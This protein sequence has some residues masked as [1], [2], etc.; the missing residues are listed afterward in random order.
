VVDRPVP[1]V[2]LIDHAKVTLKSGAKV[3]H[4]DARGSSEVVVEDGAQISHLTAKGQAV[5]R[6]LGGRISNLS[7]LDQAQAH[8]HRLRLEGGGLYSST[9]S[10][11]GII[12][13]PSAR[14]HFYA[15]IISVDFGIVRGLWSNGERFALPLIETPD[16]DKGIYRRPASMPSQLVMHELPGPSFDCTRAATPAERA[17][18]ADEGL[19]KLDK[20]LAKLYAQTLVAAADA[21]ALRRAQTRWLRERDKCSSRACFEAAYRA[22]IEAITSSAEMTNQKAQAICKTVM[23]AVNDGSIAGRFLRFEPATAEDDKRWKESHPDQFL[24]LHQVL[25]IKHQG[26]TRAIGM[27]IGGGTCGNCD[28][29]DLDAKEIELYPPDDEK[30]RLRWAS[31][32]ACDHLLMVN[33]EPV[34][35]TGSFGGGRSRASLVAWIA[36]DGAKRALCYLGPSGAVNTRFVRSDNRAL[37]HAVTEGRV[38]AVPWLDS[39]TVEKGSDR[40][41]DRRS[42]GYKAAQFDVDM[43]GSKDMIVLYGYASGAGCGSYSEWLEHGVKKSRPAKPKTKAAEPEQLGIGYPVASDVSAG[44]EA[45]GDTYVVQDTPLGQVLKD[46]ISGPIEGAGEKHERFALKMFS[47]G[48]RPYILGRGDESSASVFSVWGGK[49]RTWC[50]FDLLRQHQI[51]LYYPIETWPAGASR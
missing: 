51:E 17:I 43:D 18:C 46:R 10:G 12:Y 24:N 48:G 4:L 42:D 31:W 5:V 44:E 13:E 49:P 36:P 41:H 21:P 20:Q 22:R 25:R 6:I 45:P 28:I 35:V 19:A 40:V 34:I 27:L 37:C 11:S 32:G 7:I 16:A 1:Y 15:D 14:I 26:R 29:V 9:F 8:L 38:D 33:G 3:A 30:E 39:F 50:D 2:D 23:E 47:F